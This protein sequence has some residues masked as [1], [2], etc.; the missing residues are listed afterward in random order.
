M[1]Y[2]YSEVGD[3]VKKKRTILILSLFLLFVLFIVLTNY[4]RSGSLKEISYLELKNM[5]ELKDDFIL[6]ISN[7]YCTYCKV[8]EPKLN[9]VAKQYKLSIYKVD[10]ATFTSDENNEFKDLVGSVGTPTVVFIYDG[11][12]SGTNNRISGNV[13]V[14]KITERLKAN[15]YIKD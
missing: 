15:E 8:F 1:I 9:A 6:Y 2:F 3:Y 11:V 14:D 5:V 10:T 7:K 13:S 12:E 4:N